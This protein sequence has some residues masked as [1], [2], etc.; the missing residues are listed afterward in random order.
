MWL[1]RFCFCSNS[2]KAPSNHAQHSFF[3]CHSRSMRVINLGSGSR[4]TFF[5]GIQTKADQRTTCDKE[6]RSW[7]KML[8]AS[9][10]TFIS[11][12]RA[13]SRRFFN[14][15]SLCYTLF[16][17]LQYHLFRNQKHNDPRIPWRHWLRLAL[18]VA[19]TNS[20]LLWQFW[21][22]RTQG[23]NSNFTALI[24]ISSL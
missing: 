7:L 19:G 13:A 2:L 12:S 9:L 5:V 8:I 18:L 17:V 1:R 24:P 14:P 22:I 4:I 11:S 3:S 16:A 6:P 21:W 23:A 15:F 10:R 20:A